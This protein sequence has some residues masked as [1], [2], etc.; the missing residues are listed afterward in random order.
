MS[1]GVV[2]IDVQNAI[3]DGATPQDR[4]PAVRAYFDQTIA[5]L[6]TIRDSARTL[7]LPIFIVQNDGP[8]GDRLE[9]HTQG[10]E[11]VAPLQAKG[12]DTLIRKKNCDSFHDT[13]LLQSVKDQG[14]TH[15]V[16]GG[17]ATQ[18]CVDTSVRRAVSLGFNVTLVADG[19]A[20][21]NYG[22]LK[23][24][25]IIAHHNAVLDGLSAGEA[26]VKAV[27]TAQIDLRLL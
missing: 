17:C 14:V 25:Q 27:P 21:G 20:T 22:D 7:G 12:S 18:F 23:Q 1:V 24:H 10:W 11:V 3:V 26:Q 9:P 2:I 19:H 15:L 16:M 13:D 5:N 4:P 8:K 6:V